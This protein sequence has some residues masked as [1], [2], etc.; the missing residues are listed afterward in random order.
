MYRSNPE[1]AERGIETTILGRA[2][3]D[4]TTDRF[5]KFDLVAL[6]SRWG[7]TT[8]NGRE[9]DRGPADVGFAFTLAS[10]DAPVAPAYLWQYGW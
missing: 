1:H 3:W 4:R 6:G 7:G 8:F 10:D 2:K 9:H 5:T